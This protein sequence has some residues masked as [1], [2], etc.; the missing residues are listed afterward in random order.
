MTFFWQHFF[1]NI[2]LNKNDNVHRAAFANVFFIAASFSGFFSPHSL[3]NRA[4][5]SRWRC[6]Q[7]FLM[8]DTLTGFRFC[9]LLFFDA[10][11]ETIETSHYRD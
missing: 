1:D 8:H 9:Q 11:L 5:S 4:F 7:R 3:R 6:L 10:I 2:L